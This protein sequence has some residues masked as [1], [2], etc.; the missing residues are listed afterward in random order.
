MATSRVP[1]T[2]PQNTT[3]ARPQDLEEAL[4]ADLP[5]ALGLVAGEDDVRLTARQPWKTKPGVAEEYS[6]QSL[7]KTHGSGSKNVYPKWVA[8]VSGNMD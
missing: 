7:K 4:V 1:K 5:G 6:W 2:R 3:P 8:L